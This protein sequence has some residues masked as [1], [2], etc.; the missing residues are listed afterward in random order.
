VTLHILAKCVFSDD[1]GVVGIWSEERTT[2][3]GAC[4]VARKPMLLRGRDGAG[5]R[6]LAPLNSISGSSGSASSVEAPLV[7]YTGWPK[8]SKPPPIFQKIVL[9]IA[10]EIRFLSKVK[11]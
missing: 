11:V 10:K 4:C 3:A 5:V 2:V 9:K 7:M 6:R 1:L 8:K